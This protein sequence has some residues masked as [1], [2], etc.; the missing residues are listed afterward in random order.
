[1]IYSK[2]LA[3]AV[4]VVFW[5]SLAYISLDFANTILG[6]IGGYVTGWFMTTYL[7]KLFMKYWFGD[8]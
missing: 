7:D 6:I 8:K 4:T 3:M 5:V 2:I 1:M